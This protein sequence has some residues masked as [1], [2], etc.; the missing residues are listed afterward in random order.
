MSPSTELRENREFATE[1]KFLVAPAVAEKIREWARLCLA[2]D[3]NAGNGADGYQI[4]SLYYDT[5]E[6]H[7]F[8]RKGSYGRSKYRIR[9]YGESESVFL[10]RKLKTRGLVSKRRSIVN[11]GDLHA[12]SNGHV[13]TNWSGFWFD[14]RIR[15]RRLKLICQIT[16][17]RTARVTMT[18]QGP[19]RLTLDNQILAV[20]AKEFAFAESREGIQLVPSQVIVEMKYRMEMPALFKRLV[21]EFSLSPAAISKY[22]LAAVSL[23][24]VKEPEVAPGSGEA[25]SKTKLELNGKHD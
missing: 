13:H 11:L 25:N 23:G 12:L 18:P 15:A 4:S 16:Y 2:P 22:R 21:E 20:P 3:P 9:R 8:H 7:V 10:E 6:F 24:M 1:T 14:Q 5:D 19:I 17:Q